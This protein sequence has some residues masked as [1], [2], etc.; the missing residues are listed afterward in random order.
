MNT[1]RHILPIVRLIDDEADLRK[2]TELQCAVWNFPSADAV[3]TNYLLAAARTGGLVLGAY[4]SDDVLLGFTFTAP[5][6]DAKG[7]YHYLHMIGVR[8]GSEG[9]GIGEALLRSHALHSRSAE[10]DRVMWTY[11]PLES[12]NAALYVHKAGAIVETY[13]R[14]YYGQSQSKLHSG[15][16]T[17]RVIAWWNPSTDR[18]QESLFRAQRR[19]L[20]VWLGLGAK[21]ADSEGLDGDGAFPSYVLVPIPR[22]IQQMKIES[23]TKA[24]QW[25]INTRDLLERLLVGCGG[26]YRIIDFVSAREN[27]RQDC[28]YVLERIV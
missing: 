6:F 2:V 1:T 27:D 26:N 14:N 4:D 8:P 19:E 10:I 21:I 22:D 25:L 15:L 23:L 28:F 3:P 7:P 9:A 24:R 17:D 20:A 13:S 18:V 16:P 12:R 11:D 5:A